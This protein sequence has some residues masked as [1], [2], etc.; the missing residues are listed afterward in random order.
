MKAAESDL[1]EET[2]G[3]LYAPGIAN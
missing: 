2:E 1:F 3:L